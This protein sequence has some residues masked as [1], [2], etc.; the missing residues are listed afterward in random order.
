MF[1]KDVWEKRKNLC[2]EGIILQGLSYDSDYNKAMAIRK[3]QKEIYKKWLFYN[4]IMKA[5]KGGEK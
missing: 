1:K 5:N 4:N 2:K 3:K